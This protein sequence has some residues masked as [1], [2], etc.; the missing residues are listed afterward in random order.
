MR[1]ALTIV[2]TGLVVLGFWLMAS[3]SMGVGSDVVTGGPQIAA[4]PRTT[5]GPIAVGLAMLVGGGLFFIM[6]LRRR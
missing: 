4:A 1:I 6:L 5:V 2:A 3:G